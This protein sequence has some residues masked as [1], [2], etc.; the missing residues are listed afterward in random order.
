MMKTKSL[1]AA[2]L[3]VAA[4]LAVAQTN[5]PSKPIRVIVPFGPGSASDISAR[6]FGDQLG[7]VIGQPVVIDNRPGANA[8]IGAMA[9]K[10]APPDGYTILV[11]SWTTIAVNPVAVKDLPYDPVK[12]FKPIS[13]MT[14]SLI[15]LAVAA[16]SPYKNVQDVVRAAKQGGKPLN[17]GTFS[18]GF[19]LILELFNT[20]AGV[21]MTN[22][23]YKSSGQ[24]Q[25]DLMGRQID[26]TMD[27][28][29]SAGAMYRAGKV[30]LLAVSGERRDPA[31]PEVPTFREA[32]Y[33]DFVS[34]GW[35]SLFVRT[36]TPDDITRRLADA[37]MKVLNSTAAQD[38]AKK[39]GSELMVMGPDQTRKFQVA[40]IDKFRR[41]AQAAGV[42]PE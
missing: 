30:R 9:V 26:A 42:K 11:G 35:S 41:V 18:T 29:S 23:P 32:G 31:F 14:R 3:M 20:T 1:L 24:M 27:G 25:T 34:Y 19:H 36:E 15:G 16:D 6:F 12:D 33:P 2:L 17:V 5:F 37:M 13:G 10:N 21:K 4:P 22:I 8:V 39:L 38:F 40:E 7:S 28:T